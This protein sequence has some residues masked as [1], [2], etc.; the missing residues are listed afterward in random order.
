MTKLGIVCGLAFEAAIIE[1]AAQQLAPAPAPLI[2]CS[3]PGPD[4]ARTAA[5]SLTNQGASALLSFGISGGLDPSLETGAVVVATNLHGGT[6]PSCDSPWTARLYESLKADFKTVRAPLAGA[7]DVL[8]T[9]ADKTALFQASG[10][11]AIDMESIGIADAAADKGLPFAALRVVCDTAGET[12][13]P[14]AI[15]AMSGDGRVRTLMTLVQAL[16]HPAQIPDLVRL[17]RRTATAKN[18]LENLA[19]F[20]VL[21]LFRAFG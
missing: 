10:A 16:A 15:A 6:S 2:A 12:I 9:P 14:V 17:G 19:G 11:A 18:V 13:P 4:R 1:R 7:K 21:G 20:G 5:L 8:A 3:G